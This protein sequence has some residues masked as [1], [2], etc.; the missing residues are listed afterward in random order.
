M[1]PNGDREGAI[2]EV[3]HE[4][5]ASLFITDVTDGNDDVTVSFLESKSNLWLGNIFVKFVLLVSH[6][7]R[8]VSE[9]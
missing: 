9:Q 1:N 5:R 6:N 7:D 3:L 4:D 2:W 8:F